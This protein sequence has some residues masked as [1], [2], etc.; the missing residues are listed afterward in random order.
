MSKFHSIVSRRDFMKGIGLAGAGLGAAAATTPVFH[1]LDEVMSS[2]YSEKTR[3]WWVTSREFMDTT[4]EVDWGIMKRYDRRDNAQ[5]SNV[6]TLFYGDEMQ[7]ARDGQK[8][9]KQAQ[10]DAREPGFT[11]KTEAFYN[12]YDVVRDVVGDGFEHDFTGIHGGPMA[13][14]PEEAGV[15]RYT[16]TPEENAKLFSAATRIFG[17][18]YMGYAELDSTYR[19][20]L[21]VSHTTKTTARIE[22]EDVDQ[23]YS[24]KDPTGEMKERWVIPNKPMWA[25][26][27]GSPEALF[28][29]KT[30]PSLVSKPNMYG[31]VWMKTLYIGMFNLLRS[32]GYQMIGDMGHQTMPLNAGATAVLTGL[33]ES[34]R[35]NQYVL[36]P[37]AGPRINHE[38]VITDF[39]LAPTP[40]IDAG[41]FKFCHSCGICADTCPGGWINS[42]SEPSFDVGTYN[43]KPGIFHAAG[44]KQFWCDAAG[45]RMQFKR[46]GGRCHICYGVCPF[47][48][49]RE[50][51]MHNVVKSMVSTTSLFNG[52]FANMSTSMG[53]GL[54]DKEAWWD[55]PQPVFG[56]ESEVFAKYR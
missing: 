32:L 12:A 51:Q 21:V 20:K 9:Y 39:P 14:T 47:N 26:A 56:L 43:G 18:A 52:F 37:E 16:G 24:E 23:G 30:A 2:S 1:D 31:T 13:D 29:T 42:D 49:G 35:N 11:R 8:A 40:P 4:N 33:A 28:S 38:N 17:G 44:P 15:T 46:F 36:T 48:E 19:N 34:S 25:V 55:E 50:A 6:E 53:F 41:I 5:N 3:P 45:C 7:A 54:Q 10:I 27:Y 22:F